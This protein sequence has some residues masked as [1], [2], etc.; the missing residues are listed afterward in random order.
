M[1]HS[2]GVGRA[3]SSAVNLP[4]TRNKLSKTR[5]ERHFTT[6]S[7]LYMLVYQLSAKSV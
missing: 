5:M 4:H 1:K 2:V 6:G 3:L 7:H